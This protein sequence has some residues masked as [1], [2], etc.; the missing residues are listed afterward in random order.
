[1]RLSSGA[2]SFPEDPQQILCG[3]FGVFAEVSGNRWPVDQGALDA[4]PEPLAPLR[5]DELAEL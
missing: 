1:M 4:A 3:G 2:G 5:R